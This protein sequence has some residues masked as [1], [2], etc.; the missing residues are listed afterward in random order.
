MSHCLRIALALLALAMGA[1]AADAVSLQHLTPDAATRVLVLQGPFEFEDDAAALMSEAATFRPT[2]VTFDS[3]GGNIDA[4]IRYGRAIRAL[5]LPTIQLR[6]LQC[7]SACTLA[8]L[9]GA[10]RFAEPGSIGVHQSSFSSEIGLG[11]R[12][13]VAAVQAVTATV[14]GYMVEM[15]VDPGLLQL[16]LAIDSADIR[17]LTAAEMR[18]YRVTTVD[19]A[20]APVAPAT[21]PRTAAIAS[22]SPEGGVDRVALYSGLDFLGRDID[23]RSAANAVACS[24]L[25]M[26]N[27]ACRAFTFNVKT[28]PGRGPNCFLKSSRGQLDG[29]GSALSGLLLRRGDPA[30]QTFSFGAIDPTQSLYHD[31]DFPGGDLSRRPQAQARTPFD[32]RLACVND[33]RCAAFTFVARKKECW[34]KRGVEASRPLQGTTSGVKAAMTYVPQSIDLR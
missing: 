7:A 23:S 4:A 6:S 27:T 29:N 32:C 26:A 14:I 30:P 19:G 10:Q 13:A 31:I 1:P 8:F 11:S 21:G 3:P 5:G 18:Q 17:Y 12:E 15:G 25:C 34:L 33:A 24:D 22:P 20:T 16:S 2:A 9:G 28:R